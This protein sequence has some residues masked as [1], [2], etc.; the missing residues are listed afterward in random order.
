MIVVMT[1]FLCFSTS[2]Q[3]FSDQLRPFVTARLSLRLR[4]P[5]QLTT[6]HLEYNP[7]AQEA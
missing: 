4:H 5:N 2:H 7:S 3:T 6:R 1:F